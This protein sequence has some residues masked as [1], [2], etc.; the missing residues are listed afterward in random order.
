MAGKYQELGPLLK[1]VNQVGAERNYYDNELKRI[2]QELEITKAKYNSSHQEF[3][4]LVE[5][6]VRKKE[7]I[8]KGLVSVR[9]D[10]KNRFY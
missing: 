8:D 2:F 4:E 6:L 10:L 7:C 3:K 9:K 1:K 5:E